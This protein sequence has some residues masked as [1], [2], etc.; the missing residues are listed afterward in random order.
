[1]SGTG[2]AHAVDGIGRILRWTAG[3][4]LAAGLGL[5]AERVHFLST[6]VTTTGRVVDV[7]ASNSLCRHVVRRSVRARR[8]TLFDAR[9]EF[10]VEGRPHTVDVAAGGV[11]G[12]D[13]PTTHA[14]LRP[15]DAVAIRHAPDGDPAYRDTPASL[16][17]VPGFILLC[18]FAAGLGGW[19]RFDDE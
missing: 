18:A 10:R 7:E 12:P 13:Q 6:A 19:S 5:V 17:L 16:W 15:G 4:L 8:C 1:V 2:S 3:V 9:I 11:H 14:T